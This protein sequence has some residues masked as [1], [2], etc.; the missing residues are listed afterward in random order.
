[1]YKYEFQK[2]FKYNKQVLKMKDDFDHQFPHF[3]KQYPSYNFI[4]KFVEKCLLQK[5]KLCWTQGSAI[6]C[7]FIWNNLYVSFLKNLHE[8]QYIILH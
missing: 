1:M 7:G 3:R 2:P 8:Q 5:N 4:V 6:P